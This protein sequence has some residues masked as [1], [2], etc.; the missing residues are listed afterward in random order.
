[1]LEM[2]TSQNEKLIDFYCENFFHAPTP[3][4]YLWSNKKA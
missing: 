4:V 3:P 1:M 2:V